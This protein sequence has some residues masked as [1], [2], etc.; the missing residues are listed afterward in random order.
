MPKVHDAN[1]LCGIWI[2]GEAGTGKS[3]WARDTYP[4]AYLKPMNK[5]WDGYNGEDSVILDDIDP[6][7]NT[8][9]GYFLKMWTDR[10]AFIAEQKGTSIRIRPSIFLITSQYT[11]DEIFTDEETRAAIKRRCKVYHIDELKNST[12]D[13]TLIET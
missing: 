5:W 4:D 8:W 3:R 10:Y 13:R 1:D 11:I 12:S 9:I 7:H 2:Y 6:H